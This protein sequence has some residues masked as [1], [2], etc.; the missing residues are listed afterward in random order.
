LLKNINYW[1]KDQKPDWGASPVSAAGRDDD[2]EDDINDDVG[3][4]GARLFAVFCCSC[5]TFWRCIW[6]FLN[7]SSYNCMK[8][9]NTLAILLTGKGWVD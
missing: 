4:G 8:V 7:H 2:D 6:R 3:A 9:D 1:K 5:S